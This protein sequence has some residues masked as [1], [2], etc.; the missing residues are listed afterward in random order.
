PSALRFLGSTLADHGARLDEA[1]RLLESAIGLRPTAGD[2]ADSLGWLYLKLG[3][4]GDAERYLLRAARLLGD[5]AEVLS[6]LGALY[7][8]Q[9]DR[10]RALDV[11]RRAL[12]RK[13]EEQ[14]RHAVE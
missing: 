12:A 1:R 8:K 7:L 4:T 2:V 9:G 14:L 3:R 10:T 11:Y 13:P 5:Q 6:H